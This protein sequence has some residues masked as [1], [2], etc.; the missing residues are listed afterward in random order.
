MNEDIQQILIDYVKEQKANDENYK[1]IRDFCKIQEPRSMTVYRG[2]KVEKIHK[3]SWYS[4][5]K[6]EKVAREEFAGKEGY[7]FKIHLVN[8]PV[9]DIN[10]HIKN[11]IGHYKEEK[12]VIFLG[13]GSFYKESNCKEEGYIQLGEDVFECWYKLDPSF[14][15]KRYANLIGEEEY[16]FIDGPGDIVGFNITPGQKELVYEEIEKRKQKPKNGGGRKKTKR[17]QFKKKKSHTRRFS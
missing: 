12:E 9:I 14:D 4:S 11:K 1:K 8:I 13:G 16:D 2:Q 7:V 10:K 3:R 15:V 5:T 6:L 17:R